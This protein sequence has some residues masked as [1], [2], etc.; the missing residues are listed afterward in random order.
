MAKQ[1][2]KI[3]KANRLILKKKA[4]RSKYV[5]VTELKELWKFFGIISF[6][7]EPELFIIDPDKLSELE[8]KLDSSVWSKLAAFSMAL[9]Q[10]S[11]A[12]CKSADLIESKMIKLQRSKL[13]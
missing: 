6:V 10:S 4:F 9:A 7:R 2:I 12:C 3:V 8:S 13:V 5:K 1:S 11:S